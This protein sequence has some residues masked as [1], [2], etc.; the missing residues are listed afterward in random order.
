M[1]L[2]PLDMGFI[3]SDNSSTR[4]SHM[5][6]LMY[7][8][9]LYNNSLSDFTNMQDTLHPTTRHESSRFIIQQL[10]HTKVAIHLHHNNQE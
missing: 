10:A 5:W 2:S 9:E 1:T 6:E 7:Q 8:T 4:N 3:M